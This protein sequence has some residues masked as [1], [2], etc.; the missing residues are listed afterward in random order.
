MPPAFNAARQ[1][2]QSA[3]APHPNGQGF[4]PAPR[5][6]RF[7]FSMLRCWR[8]AKCWK[9]Q[10]QV[11][12]RSYVPDRREP[13]ALRCPCFAQAQGGRQW[14]PRRTHAFDPWSLR[15]KLSALLRSCIAESRWFAIHGEP[16][17]AHAT[18]PMLI[19]GTLCALAYGTSTRL[20]LEFRTLIFVHLWPTVTLRQKGR[21]VFEQTLQPALD[22]ES[23][24]SE[25]RVS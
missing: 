18:S 13:I 5:S 1:P 12:T 25:F 20:T 4:L 17:S 7:L 14:P 11:V 9:C 24:R 16:N 10:T 2:H 6:F 19:N 23:P 15:A 3:F 21:H 8:R 22:C